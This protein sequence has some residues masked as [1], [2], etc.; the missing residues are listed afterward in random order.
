M[1]LKS[2]EY[3]TEKQLHSDAQQSQLV[4]YLSFYISHS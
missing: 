3:F 2:K 1:F 4:I